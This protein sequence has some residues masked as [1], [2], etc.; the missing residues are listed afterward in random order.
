MEPIPDPLPEP[1]P[2]PQPELESVPEHGEPPAPVNEPDAPPLAQPSDSALDSALDPGP[3]Q[4][5]ESPPQLVRS[6]KVDDPSRSEVF[7]LED[8]RAMSPKKWLETIGLPPVFFDEATEQEVSALHTISVLIK[9]GQLKLAQ[10]ELDQLCPPA[11]NKSEHMPFGWTRER[12][13]S[14]STTVYDFKR[15]ND[16][17]LG[18]ARQVIAYHAP[19]IGGLYGDLMRYKPFTTSRGKPLE[20]ADMNAAPMYMAEHTVRDWT[21][22]SKGTEGAK[23]LEYVTTETAATIAK[24]Y[25]VASKGRKK[26]GKP[27]KEELT[28]QE[29]TAIRIYT[30]DPYREINAV[31][32]DFRVDAAD[33]TANWEKYSMIARLAISGLGKLPKFRG[34]YSYRGDHD[35][36][37]GGLSTVLRKGAIFRLPCFYGTSQFEYGAFGGDLGYVFHNRKRAR[38]VAPFSAHATEYEVL[39]PPGTPFKIVAEYN[40]D[41]SGNWLSHD[42]KPIELSPQAAALEAQGKSRRKRIIEL[43]EIA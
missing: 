11:D 21:T 41:D 19:D 18:A 25:T 34:V 7:S 14:T 2:E 20:R 43:E 24:G 26:H 29:V 30:A 3:P 9:D 1:Q 23:H 4:L 31:F 28:A 37:Y 8:I 27:D 42:N 40:K 22:I 36:I 17:M 32:R 39:I 15:H 12:Y 5:Q 38:W 35:M 33:Y 13:E 16:R 6:P 10:Y